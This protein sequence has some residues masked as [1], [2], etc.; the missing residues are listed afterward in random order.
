MYALFCLNTMNLK[1]RLSIIVPCYNMEKY[2]FRCLSSLLNQDIPCSEYEILV[3][4]DGSVDGT[5]S[6]L[7]EMAELHSCIRVIT[8]ANQGAGSA[9]NTGIQMAKGTYIWFVDGDDW[10]APNSLKTLLQLAETND[11]D[12]LRFDYWHVNKYIK[13]EKQIECPD[14]VY[15][16]PLDF[17]R[18]KIKQRFFLFSQFLKRRIITE[19]QLQ[20]QA[21]R[22]CEDVPF[23]SEFVMHAKKI[24]V[25]DSVV[26]FYYNRSNSLVNSINISRSQDAFEAYGQLKKITLPYMGYKKFANYINKVTMIQILKEFNLYKR[27]TKEEQRK[28]V[29][30]FNESELSDFSIVYMDVSVRKVIY[31]LTIKHPQFFFFLCR[32]WFRCERFLKN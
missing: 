3:V 4:N 32:V 31:A 11:L 23:L 18:K 21:L 20:F 9:R 27:L 2:I 29:Q 16:S 12:I 5:L 8:T 30:A 19:N 6:I 28:F 1:M 17:F 7:N 22:M 10:V 24:G 14:L 15:F 13:P 26:Y 25:I